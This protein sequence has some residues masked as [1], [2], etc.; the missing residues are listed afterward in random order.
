[1]PPAV[2]TALSPGANPATS[3]AAGSDPEGSDTV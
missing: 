2:M 3:A 1:V